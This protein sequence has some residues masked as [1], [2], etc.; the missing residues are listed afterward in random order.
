MCRQSDSLCV[1]DRA[2]HQSS[3]KLGDTPL[4]RLDLF[5]SLPS[6]RFGCRASTTL[7]QNRALHR[8]T[9]DSHRHAPDVELYSST[10]LQSAL[11]LYSS[12]ALYIL[13]P[14]HPPSACR[15]HLSSRHPSKLCVCGPDCGSKVPRRSR[16][17]PPPARG[18]MSVRESC[19][20]SLCPTF[21]SC[22]GP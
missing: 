15:S 14:L 18:G 16:A 19:V 1:R 17:P 22:V 9:S 8:S 11:H 12:T 13:H 21:F 5:E 6:R 20:L 2:V 4:A 3:S 10:A 7:Q